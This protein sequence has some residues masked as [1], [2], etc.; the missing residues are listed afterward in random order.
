MERAP[1]PWPA[2]LAVIA[3]VGFA[4]TRHVME[5]DSRQRTTQNTVRPRPCPQ[6]LSRCSPV[7]RVQRLRGMRLNASP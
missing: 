3:L 2:A 1:N 6:A 4:V 5:R 7:E